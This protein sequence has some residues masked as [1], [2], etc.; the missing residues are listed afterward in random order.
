MMQDAK[1]TP[2]YELH[3]KLGGKLVEFGGWAL[4]VSY[5]TILAEHKA[6]REACGLF[7]VS[8]MGEFA[9]SGSGATDFLNKMLTNDF[10]NMEIGRCRYSPMCYDDGGTVDDLLVAKRRE[11]RYMIIVNASNAEKDFAWLTEHLTGD[12]QLEDVSANT[13]LLALQGPLFRD[14]LN[15]AGF[16][17]DLP[18]KPYRFS[19]HAMIAGK[20][21]LVATT[22]YT[23]E[24][25]IEIYLRPGDATFVA[26]AL[27]EAGSV[28]CGLGARDTLRFE[29]SMPL[30]GHELA[31]DITPLECGLSSFVKLQKP[32]DFIGKAA[33]ASA[34][35]MRKRIGL[36]ILDRGIA[37]EGCPVLLENGEVVG[38]TTSGGPAPTIGKN[39][40]MALVTIDAAE[41]EN[42]MIEVRGRKLK[43][44]KT[45]LPFFKS[46]N[47]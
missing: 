13:A 28:P 47:R 11:T 32:M 41:Q 8:H 42:F 39:M 14:V 5:T 24:P 9:L 27:L 31:K 43:A 29:C 37:R 44:Q 25:G 2:L 7:D 12:V 45:R 35:V 10:T 20:P 6:V 17:G 16:E 4:P 38:V 15:K 33:L 18:D 1:R 22:G 34:P 30:Y 23:G 19:E 21:C 26:E 46:T 3:E 36:E 40:A